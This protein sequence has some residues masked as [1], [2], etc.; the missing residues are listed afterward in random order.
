MLRLFSTLF[1]MAM[2][3]GV[4]RSQASLRWSRSF[5]N[6][7]QMNQSKTAMDHLGNTWCMMIVTDAMSFPEQNFNLN[8]P[9]NGSHSLVRINSAGK[10]DRVAAIETM[11]GWRGIGAMACSPTNELWVMAPF[12]ETV[13]ERLPSDSATVKSEDKISGMLLTAI[14][15]AGKIQF[16]LN[17]PVKNTDNMVDLSFDSK[18]HCHVITQWIDQQYEPYNGQEVKSHKHYHLYH[19][20]ISPEGII[21]H[22]DDINMGEILFSSLSGSRIHVTPND[23]FYITTRYAS[24]IKMN[25]EIIVKNVNQTSD[26]YTNVKTMLCCFIS[27][28]KENLSGTAHSPVMAL[29]SSHRLSVIKPMFI[30]RSI[31]TMNVVSI[32]KMK[33]FTITSHQLPATDFCLQA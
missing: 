11:T 26:P 29:N 19:H 32:K 21:L 25:D 24:F 12:S 10:T 5:I 3:I 27:I 28:E 7:M 4:V 9:S 23:D 1:L 13:R 16:A 17:L 2:L 30:S 18:G 14:S 31:F 33:S 22:S 8:R 6:E 15:P 20:L